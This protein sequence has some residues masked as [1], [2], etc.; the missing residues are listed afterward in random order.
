MPLS[1]TRRCNVC[2]SC[3][4]TRRPQQGSGA[5]G[6][7]RRLDTLAA[8][9]QNLRTIDKLNSGDLYGTEVG[10]DRVNLSRAFN[11]LGRKASKTVSRKQRGQRLHGR[12]TSLG[13]RPL[14][15]QPPSWGCFTSTACLVSS[16]EDFAPCCPVRRVCV[17]SD[18][19]VCKSSAYPLDPVPVTESTID[20]SFLLG[21]AWELGVCAPMRVPQGQHRSIGASS[22]SFS[23]C[24][25]RGS[26]K[27]EE[28]TDRP[29]LLDLIHDECT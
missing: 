1:R 13:S 12:R 11:F 17:L 19:W 9:K 22:S 10:G 27:M 24:R 5:I 2:S 8:A 25:T 29:L 23:G 16:V 18:T 15:V 21:G 6:G 7:F 26:T 4:G 28:E 14:L 3:V 20:A